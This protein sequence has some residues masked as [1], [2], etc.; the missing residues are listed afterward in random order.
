MAT[1]EF[2]PD[3]L[4]AE[5]VVFRGFTTPELGFTALFSLLGGL[6]VAIPVL[7]FLGW[8]AFP[9]VS[10]LMPLVTIIFGGRLMARFKRGKPENYLYRR[11]DLLLSH[12]GL[13]TKG[14]IQHSQVLAL[15]RLRP[16][17]RRQ[18]AVHE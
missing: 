8:I 2:M 6:V 11:L 4:N 12:S 9:T 7:P 15:R 10:L 5:P 3:R 14:L 18:E 1:I 16:V 13:G 17:V